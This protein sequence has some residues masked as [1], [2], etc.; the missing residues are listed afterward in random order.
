LQSHIRSSK[1]F[2]G[3]VTEIGDDGVDLR[4]VDVREVVGLCLRGVKGAKGEG[5]GK[6]KGEKVCVVSPLWLG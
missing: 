6:G 2:E 3:K 1:R 5:K 4:E